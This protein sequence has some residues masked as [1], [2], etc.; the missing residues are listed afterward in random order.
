MEAATAGEPR[1][2]DHQRE[3]SI[4]LPQ[5]LFQSITHMAPAAAIAFSI[6][7]SVGFSGPAL[8]LSVL[9]AL[10]AFAVEEETGEPE[11]EAVVA[12]LA[13]EPGPA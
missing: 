12:S 7:V 9:F 2:F 5:V 1:R 11:D 13:P 4:G 10:V 8:P 6:L 3:H